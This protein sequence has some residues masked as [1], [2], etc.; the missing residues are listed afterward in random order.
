[1]SY[2]VIIIGTG[3]AGYSTAKEFRK[4]DPDTPLIIISS[5]TGY[6]Y[7][8]PMLSN[9]LAKKQKPEELPMA[10]S[11]KMSETLGATITVNCTVES[12]DTNNKTIEFNGEAIRYRSLVLAVGANQRKLP[13]TGDAT[14]EIYSIND[15]DEYSRFRTALNNARTI[16]VIGA[17]LIGTEFANDLAASGFEV[18]VIE[19]FPHP[20]GRLV[21]PEVGNRVQQAITALGVR[22]HFG[23]TC[24]EVWQTKSGY[25]MKLSDQTELESDI[26]LSAVGLEPRIKLAESAGIS[27]NHGIKVDR[28][29][30]T[31]ADDV[32]ALGDCMEIEGLVLPYIMPIMHASRA[33]GKTLTGEATTLTYPVMPVAV[34]TPA[35]PVV[36]SPDVS[37]TEGSWSVEGDEDGIKAI[38]SS[39]SGDALGFVLTGGKVKERLPMSKIVPPVL[40]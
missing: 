27:V 35:H 39:N 10:D 18:D 29:L 26:V 17:G 24:S 23:C 5:D 4:L 11:L 30:Q 40:P 19:P 6:A 38:F 14:D 28:H 25:R 13:F 16:A 21:P 20:L 3:L 32:Y 2:P 1:M 34:K 33:L 15:L 8:K 31:S 7:S 36:V 12:I 22:W 9:A 37:G